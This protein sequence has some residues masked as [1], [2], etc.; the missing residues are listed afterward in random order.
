MTNNV[1]Q[2]AAP[3][4]VPTKHLQR[5][6]R[7]MDRWV[8]IADKYIINTHLRILLIHQS[9]RMFLRVGRNAVTFT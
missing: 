1:V 5:T 4:G 6:D 2:N 7:R 9:K 8:E 3:L